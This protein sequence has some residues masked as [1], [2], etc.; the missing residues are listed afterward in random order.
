MKVATTRFGEVEVPDDTLITFPEGLPPFEGKRYILLHREDSP[1]IEWLQ[2]VEEPDVALMDIW[3]P[4]L[5]G[6]DATR[7]IGKRGLDTKVLVLSMHES[8][9]YVEEVL[10]AGAAGYIVKTA[11]P[12]DLLNAIDAVH[13]H[14]TQVN[15]VYTPT[16][17][18]STR[19]TNGQIEIRV[20]DNGPGIQE[21]IREKIFEPF[22]TTK[23]TG[24]GAGLGLSLAYEMV[25]QGHGGRLHVQSTEGEGAMFVITLPNQS[26]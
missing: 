6:I 13:G 12:D 16:V 17:T 7:R 20:S 24:T 18:V 22:F 19:Q 25:T 15:G 11:A 4:R 23:P 26:P 2:S 14:A 10:R 5:S 9:T 21:E 8:R 3:M 1:M